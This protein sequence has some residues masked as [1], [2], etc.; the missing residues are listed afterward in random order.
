MRKQIGNI[1]ELRI[2]FGEIKPDL[3]PRNWEDPWEVKRFM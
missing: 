2:I 1:K 3:S